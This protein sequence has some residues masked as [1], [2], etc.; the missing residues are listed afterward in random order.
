MRIM[1][2]AGGLL[3]T[4]TVVTLLVFHPI[5]GPSSAFGQALKQVREARSISFTE[6]LAQKDGKEPIRV[7]KWIAADGRMR[8]ELQNVTTIFDAA[9]NM[10]ITLI[11][12]TKTALVMKQTKLEGAGRGVLAWLEALKKLGDKPDKEL[13]QRVV[14]GKK[15]SGFVAA[16]GNM[17]FTIWV[18][19]ATKQLVSVE[20]DSP[21]SGTAYQHVSMI[22]FRFDEKLDE[23]L[24]SFAVPKGYAERQQPDVPSVPG[25]EASVIE[26]L[27]GWTK[28]DGGKFP[29]SLADWGPWAVLFSKD[30]RD[31]KLDAEATR[32][33]AHLGAITPFLISMTKDSYAYLGDGKTVAQ[34]EEIVFWYKKPD[35]AYRA[36][37]GDLS[38]KDI[39]AE[40]LP[41]K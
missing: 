13:G 38:V 15:Q 7:K 40:D 4:A 18:D 6:V 9:G 29:P 35:G 8:N 11:E 25:G 24:F 10:R 5:N 26:A 36:I 23:S 30:S 19:D 37:Y 12:G 22:E 20:Y 28:R 34:K 39:K 2:T 16:Q 27:R 21:I 33:L 31:G 32:V 14:D 1:T 3:A 17:T 41:K